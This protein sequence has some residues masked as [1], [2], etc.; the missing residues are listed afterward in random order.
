[1]MAEREDAMVDSSTVTVDD[2]VEKGCKVQ[3]AK[4][5][6]EKDGV[7]GGEHIEQEKSVDEDGSNGT[8]GA[9]KSSV[10]QDK[11]ENKQSSSSEDKPN[12][13]HI[14]I[15]KEEDVKS[16]NSEDVGG[17]K[18]SKKKT[19][20]MM[21]KA[22]HLIDAK[23]ELPPKLSYEGIT[24]EIG[25]RADWLERQRDR[26]VK[27]KRLSKQKDG[28]YFSYM[29][30]EKIFRESR[31]CKLCDT[32][33]SGKPLTDDD[34]S[35]DLYVTEKGVCG[36]QLLICGACGGIQAVISCENE[37]EIPD[38]PEYRIDGSTVRY[39]CKK[40]MHFNILH[41]L[42]ELLHIAAL[43]GDKNRK[44]KHL[45]LAEFMLHN[46]RKVC[47]EWCRPESSELRSKK[48][49]RL[50][51]E[52]L[53][54]RHKPVFTNDHNEEYR[55]MYQMMAGSFR[56]H[57]EKVKLLLE[58]LK[59]T[60]F[61]N[62]TYSSFML[63]VA[64]AMV[65]AENYQQFKEMYD[66][67]TFMEV[68]STEYQALKD[69]YLAL[70]VAVGVKKIPIVFVLFELPRFYH[71]IEFLKDRVGKERPTSFLTEDDQKN[72]EKFDRQAHKYL[73][74]RKMKSGRRVSAES[75]L[76]MLM[77]REEFDREIIF[78]NT[79]E[80]QRSK[81]EDKQR[82]KRMKREERERLALKGAKP[83]SELKGDESVSS[84]NS[85]VREISDSL[86]N[87]EKKQR[88]CLPYPEYRQHLMGP[89][90]ERTS[91]EQDM[92]SDM[93]LR[94]P[95]KTSIDLHMEEED[96]HYGMQGNWS[97]KDVLLCEEDMMFERKVCM[98]FKKP[99]RS[100]LDT[101]PFNMNFP[102]GTGRIPTQGEVLLLI[103]TLI[104]E[105][106]VPVSFDGACDKVFS[107]QPRNLGY[108]LKPIEEPE[109]E[110]GNKS[111]V[112]VASGGAT[113]GDLE[114][115][116]EE[117]DVAENVKVQNDM[118]KKAVDNTA[119]EEHQN[120]I[121]S[122]ED[123]TKIAAIVEEKEAVA[124]DKEEIENESTTTPEVA[125]ESTTTT[126][127]VVTEST[128]QKGATESTTTTQEVVTESTTQ[129][130]ATESTTTTQ[131]VVTES[132][133]QKG[134]TEST[135]T[136]QEVVTESTP[137]VATESTATT[138]EVVT[139]STTQ[140]GATESTTTT[141][142]VVTESTTQKG[143]TES[144]TTQEVVTESTT[145]KVATESTTTPE[146]TTV[147]TTM[148][149][150][151]VK[152]S[153]TQKVATESTTTQEVATESTTT[154]QEV[155]KELTTQ[156]AVTETIEAIEV[157]LAPTVKETVD[158]AGGEKVS[159]TEKKMAETAE[160]MN[161][162]TDSSEYMPATD[163]LESD[164]KKTDSITPPPSSK[165]ASEDTKIEKR[166][167]TL[168]PDV[169]EYVI[170][171]PPEP[172]NDDAHEERGDIK[173]TE[174]D[175]TENVVKQEKDITENETP[176]TD[177]AT[178]VS[179]VKEK[180][181]KSK[182][183]ILSYDRFNF[184]EEED[185]DDDD[186]RLRKKFKRAFD[187]EKWG[188]ESDT[189]DVI[190]PAE[191]S[192][193]SML[194]HTTSSGEIPI[195]RFTIKTNPRRP[196]MSAEDQFVESIAEVCCE[197]LQNNMPKE[198][199]NGVP[200]DP[201][202]LPKSVI[203]D[204]VDKVM[205]AI[206]S[207]DP[208]N[209]PP[210]VAKVFKPEQLALPAASTP[211]PS[212]PAA[213]PA[214]TESEKPSVEEQKPSENQDT[215]EMLQE[216][217]TPLPA[218]P[219][220][221]KDSHTETETND[222]AEKTWAS[223]DQ[224]QKAKEELEEK[225]KERK[226]KKKK[227]KNKKFEKKAKQLVEAVQRRKALEERYWAKRLLKR[228]PSEEAFDKL[229]ENK[230]RTLA[231][232]SPEEKR[233]LMDHCHRPKQREEEWDRKMMGKTQGPDSMRSRLRQKLHDR[234]LEDDYPSSRSYSRYTEVK[235]EPKTEPKPSA[236]KSKC[237][238]KSKAAA[239]TSSKEEESTSA[240][241]SEESHDM[242]SPISSP[243]VP[244]SE[245]MAEVN[246][247]LEKIEKEASMPKAE[248]MKSK[249]SKPKEDATDSDN[250]SESKSLVASKPPSPDQEKAASE[251]N[252]TKPSKTLSVNQKTLE[253]AKSSKVPA[254]TMPKQL[255]V[256]SAPPENRMISVGQ[257]RSLLVNHL[258]AN[259][260]AEYEYEQSSIPSAPT[261]RATIS[262][263]PHG[264]QPDKTVSLPPPSTQSTS[265]AGPLKLTKKQR[266][267]ARK[268]IRKQNKQL[269]VAQ[270]DTQLLRERGFKVKDD[271]TTTTVICNKDGGIEQVLDGI[272]TPEQISELLGGTYN[273]VS[274][275]TGYLSVPD[276]KSDCDSEPE[277]PSRSY[278]P[279]KPKLET[280]ASSTWTV[281]LGE[282]SDDGISGFPLTSKWQKEKRDKFKKV[283][284]KGL[285]KAIPIEQPAELRRMSPPKDELLELEELGEEER[286]AMLAEEKEAEKREKKRRKRNEK[287][288]SSKQKKETEDRDETLDEERANDKIEE[289]EIEKVA[290]EE[291]VT[292]EETKPIKPESTPIELQAITS[293]GTMVVH[294]R[295][296]PKEPPFDPV[297]IFKDQTAESIG[298]TPLLLT[299]VPS[300][301]TLDDM[302]DIELHSDKKNSNP[303]CFIYK[304]SI[305]NGG[306]R[307]P[308]R[309]IYRF[310]TKRRE[311]LDVMVEVSPITCGRNMEDVLCLAGKP[312]RVSYSCK[313]LVRELITPFGRSIYLLHYIL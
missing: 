54:L 33:D 298:M 260:I 168:A 146:V 123:Q 166:D 183:D 239:T 256:S 283:L 47:K 117:I 112:V 122:E 114:T 141:Q 7:E 70:N 109:G 271:S 246:E 9:S 208:D 3:A 204:V 110:D 120:E 302:E 67:K 19:K 167:D 64:I 30:L 213:P 259:E 59:T 309:D 200:I 99:N 119:G 174:K 96:R 55:E 34:S 52:T 269:L 252:E 306:K 224:R 106:I 35:L 125:T 274:S 228:T 292:T 5:P 89:V 280:A 180:E 219:P 39:Y 273:V 279:T 17:G 100:Y 160:D 1:M 199:R 299:N 78:R 25:G 131:E 142:E 104:E 189:Q 311:E 300:Y 244:D 267:D 223:E 159:L 210:E 128:T 108:K 164:M 21:E 229:M 62:P 149:Q 98:R 4:D 133:T 121:K 74:K 127:E 313:V 207:S 129:K 105:E 202:D 227:R 134:A 211:H 237:K 148:T 75:H 162:S 16:K 103:E 22:L 233:I 226:E 93:T 288:K 165:T 58:L 31:K 278:D 249:L 132:T 261:I 88:S 163:V 221:D 18:M 282:R 49:V 65:H 231:E 218:E 56:Q 206:V 241:V 181:D 82:V 107:I 264:K 312:G 247:K 145:Q 51:E 194:K 220:E 290:K 32:K 143:A 92:V 258:K 14:E 234:R 230:D 253:N 257:F 73:T 111:E 276:D 101:I 263:R 235:T 307:H 80:K 236:A 296:K 60:L 222:A 83:K 214:A 184:D 284:M 43:E 15:E 232:L 242:S 139:E 6:A 84:G 217:A 144:T 86:D 281:N 254:M 169:P 102:L 266:K 176:S 95:Y 191:G 150:E 12:S 190:T 137:E 182:R 272:E 28:S 265:N 91:L 71:Y 172:E 79:R 209:I 195:H 216:T 77:E 297:E 304:V 179:K 251:I 41:D 175:I 37:S 85:V 8:D 72:L 156:E 151:V 185:D 289:Q 57:K 171:P 126:Q 68:D 286:M 198:D 90:R 23:D 40:V 170:L 201:N 152:E 268:L 136:T 147:S 135:T 157:D 287:K 153:T 186:T 154:T 69:R 20:R 270:V 81:R 187:K 212:T 205:V 277:T 225:Q 196:N 248:P 173:P 53:L 308:F 10:K 285:G 113:N 295:Q 193:F 130:G 27:N 38:K 275:G 44:Q 66:P 158:V 255:G 178:D 155:V 293:D 115:T 26:E 177:E 238:S 138:Q 46:A 240:A 50:R 215:K 2:G 310:A 124:I 13:S 197:Y 291:N 250:P 192:L 305:A 94:K 87:L 36:R 42:M 140:K 29:F 116:A 303:G 76:D 243:P 188:Q 97:R 262:D 301:I 203:T 63:W 245:R 61:D 118:E 11:T 48:F 161:V 24:P 294:K 45:E